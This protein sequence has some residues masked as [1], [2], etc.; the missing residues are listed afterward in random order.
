MAFAF[1][2]G[3]ST[4]IILHDTWKLQ[5]R[6]THYLETNLAMP[7]ARHPWSILCCSSFL[8]TSVFYPHTDLCRMPPQ[9][10]N[11][12]NGRDFFPL[13]WSQLT[14]QDPEQ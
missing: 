10:C 5:V 3:G 14:P 7:Q 1:I 8:S 11:H 4:R 13:F 6:V 9:E 2:K 12:H